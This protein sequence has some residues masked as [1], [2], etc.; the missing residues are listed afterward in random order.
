MEIPNLCY[1]FWHKKWEFP[2]SIT[3]FRNPIVKDKIQ[4]WKF[5]IF[6]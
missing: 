6:N 3:I 1:Y 5:Q 4:T 2:I